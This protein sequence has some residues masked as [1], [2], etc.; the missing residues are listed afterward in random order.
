MLP[1][2]VQTGVTLPKNIRSPL[3]FSAD[4][5]LVYCVV[6]FLCSSTSLFCQE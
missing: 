3:V 6:V 5:S 4:Q 1:S 2:T